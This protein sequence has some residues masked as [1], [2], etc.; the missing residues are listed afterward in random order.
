MTHAW[1]LTINLRCTKWKSRT[2]KF[3]PKK[4]NPWSM[5]TLLLLTIGMRR[6]GFL[7]RGAAQSIVY[8]PALPYV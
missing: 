1:A 3:V 4:P 5:T 7:I 6:R 8:L 2:L